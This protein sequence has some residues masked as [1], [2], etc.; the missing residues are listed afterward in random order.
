MHVHRTVPEVHAMNHS[1]RVLKVSAT[2]DKSHVVD[3]M[4]P[5][6]GWVRSERSAVYE[7]LWLVVGEPGHVGLGWACTGR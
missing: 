2:C 5:Q 3:P 1:R 4:L 6:L 7:G